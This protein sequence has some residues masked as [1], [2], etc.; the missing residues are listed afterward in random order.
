MVQCIWGDIKCQELQEQ[1]VIRGY[2]ILS[3]EELIGKVYLMK[4][5]IEKD[6]L[7]Q[8][9]NIGRNVNIEYLDTALWTIMY[10]YY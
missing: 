6:L 1:K 5:L 7:K 8:W 2:I 9:S 4:I 3:Y 10:I